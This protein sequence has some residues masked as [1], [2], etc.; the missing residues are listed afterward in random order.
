MIRY[1][2]IILVATLIWGSTFVIVK[3]MTDVLPPAW[4]LGVRFSCAAIILAVV[5]LKKRS[6]YLTKRH[7]IGGAACGLALFVAYYLQTVGITDTTPGKNAFLTSTYCVIVP[8]I[9]WAVSHKR[10]TSRNIIAAILCLIGIGLISLQHGFTIGFGDAMTLLCAVFF[11]LHIVLVARFAQECDIYVLTIWQF[12]TVGIC[13]WL[14]ALIWDGSPDVGAV[15]LTTWAALAY[16][17][18]FATTLALLFQNI[19]QAHL[20]PSSAALLLTT[21][22]VFGVIF[23]VALGYESLTVPIV[24]GFVVVFAAI[25][26]SEVGPAR[27]GAPKELED[28]EGFGNPLP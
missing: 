1:R 24:I 15:P 14:A 2:L 19:G 27:K 9:A 8:F 11:A 5:F 6:L 21:E 7:I 16:L 10:P 17:T 25:V 28:G 26:I 23:S 13:S 4:I 12:A 18:V 20:P 22:A 3:D